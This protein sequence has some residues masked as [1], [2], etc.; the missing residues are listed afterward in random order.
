MFSTNHVIDKLNPAGS[1]GCWLDG[2]PKDEIRLREIILDRR[3]CGMVNDLINLQP[4]QTAWYETGAC[5]IIS[6]IYGALLASPLNTL[7]PALSVQNRF[8]GTL[9]RPK[10]CLQEVTSLSLF[11]DDIERLLRD[12]YGDIDSEALERTKRS[13][14][15]I[16]QGFT[17]FVRRDLWQEHE[18][19]MDWDY[20]RGIGVPEGYSISGSQWRSGMI[21][22][23]DLRTRARVVTENPSTFSKYTVA[24]ATIH[25]GEFIKL[26]ESDGAPPSDLE[27]VRAALKQEELRGKAGG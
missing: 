16:V 19:A 17:R 22:C 20:I 8:N 13:V 14:L 27:E 2:E 11:C 24:F 23:D 12:L 5:E 21:A 7:E 6:A 9:K 1:K 18:D 10:T 25:L 4:G 3:L 26:E 15:T